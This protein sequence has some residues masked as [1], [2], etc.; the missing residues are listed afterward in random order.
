MLDGG[1]KSILDR[2]ESNES[3]RAG[4]EGKLNLALDFRGIA[5]VSGIRVATPGVFSK[6]LLLTG[7]YNEISEFALAI[8]LPGV[9][10][11]VG[12]VMVTFIAGS[13]T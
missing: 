5:G 2:A 4:V 7:G 6:D 10:S 11:V 9:L 12:D 8:P 13:T 1:I 3:R